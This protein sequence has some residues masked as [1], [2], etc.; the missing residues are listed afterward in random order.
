MGNWKFIAGAALLA[1]LLSLIAGIFSGSPFAVILLRVVLSGLA[2][3]VISIGVVTLIKR[4]LPELLQM[5]EMPTAAAGID[6]LI[7]E[8]NPHQSVEVA[9]D[10]T[11]SVPVE[12]VED[13]LAVEGNDSDVG[14][15]ETEDE[16]GE[17]AD[18]LEAV[19][20]TEAG[21]DDVSGGEEIFASDT[22]IRIGKSEALPDIDRLDVGFET[23]VDNLDHS[24]Q[25]TG[26]R[27]ESFGEAQV[28]GLSANQDPEVL[29][30]AVRTFMNKDQEG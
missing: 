25:K 13:L 8:E 6:I 4:F 11:P 21:V 12:A 27:A 16:S 20:E 10:E 5:S 14:S 22:S 30:K 19:G 7:P 1:G 29:A 9:G 24:V 3:G 26:G 2:L 23:G 15:L 17:E 18:L 28:G